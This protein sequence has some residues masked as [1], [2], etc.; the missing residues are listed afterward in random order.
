[1]IPSTKAL[2]KAALVSMSIV[3]VLGLSGVP[4]ATAAPAAV[5]RAAAPATGPTSN[6]VVANAIATLDALRSGD[7]A[8]YQSAMYDLASVVGNTAGIDGLMLI[9]AWNRADSTRMTVLLSALS[10]V[11]VP[12]RKNSST[13]GGGFDCSG[14]VSWAWSQ[15][16]VELSHQ[17]RSIINEVAS[18]SRDS[19]LAGDVIYYPGHI[20]IA[21]GVGDSY[22]HAPNPGR[23]VEVKAGHRNNKRLK[24]GNPLA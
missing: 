13:P 22:V 19:V 17:S 7:V 18:T 5:V 12:Y 11:G 3:S 4:T 24:F 9:D 8:L 20:S 15:A 1:M 16:G 23:T 10:Q 2:A 21:L 14:L 6:P